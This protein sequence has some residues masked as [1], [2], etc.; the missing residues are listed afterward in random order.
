MFKASC[1]YEAGPYAESAGNRDRQ[2]TALKLPFVTEQ[3]SH[4]EVSP[5][6]FLETKRLWK[7]GKAGISA[8]QAAPLLASLCRRRR[9]AHQILL[10]HRKPP[11]LAHCVAGL[12]QAEAS[13]RLGAKVT[14]QRHSQPAEQ[15]II[16]P[17]VR[18]TQS[19][20]PLLLDH[21]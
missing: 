16:C 13:K 8:S 15:G 17:I 21:S 19:Q 1:G 10:L 7:E 12:G 9:L 18:S 2:E 11:L 20:V 3:S 4:Q 14:T 6:M 5:K